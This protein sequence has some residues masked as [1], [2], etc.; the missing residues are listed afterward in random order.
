MREGSEAI[1]PMIELA[2]M[3]G[4]TGIMWGE[5]AEIEE[6]FV[7]W[8][9]EWEQK[10][11]ALLTYANGHPSDE[12]KELAREVV[13]EM[14]TSLGATR[15]LFLSV[16][17]RGMSEG[18]DTFHNSEKRQQEAIALAEHLLEKIRRY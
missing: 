12:A 11:A 6:R 2:R 16:H 9:D 17:T 5:R 4:P 18:M 7:G 3:V 14:S 8:A 15:Y 1:T 13:A 10:R